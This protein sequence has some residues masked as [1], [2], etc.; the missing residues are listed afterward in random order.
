LERK[1][2]VKASIHNLKPGFGSVRF[3]KPDNFLSAQSLLYSASGVIIK[4][5]SINLMWRSVGRI[6]QFALGTHPVRG[7]IVLICTSLS[8]DPLKVIKLCGLR[9]K[10]EASFMQAI[11]TPGT[12]LY[13]FWMKIMA[14]IRKGSG[15]QNLFYRNEKYLKAVQRK[16]DAYHCY[17]KFGCFT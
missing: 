13:H 16:L 5:R 9:F 1:G 11:H 3:N 14:H 15:D 12:Y 4:Y 8:I 17:L 2:Q 6:V 10:I 7:N